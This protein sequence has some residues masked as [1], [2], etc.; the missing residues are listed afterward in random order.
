M[1]LAVEAALHD[2]ESF[3]SPG[4]EYLKWLESELRNVGA[5]DPD[6]RPKVLQALDVPAR[7][8]AAMPRKRSDEQLAAVDSGTAVPF[9]EHE[10]EFE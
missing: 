7:R 10:Y 1:R 8:A 9:S 4:L 6:G 5:V 2:S 3:A